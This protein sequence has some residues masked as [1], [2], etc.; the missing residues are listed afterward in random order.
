[1]ARLIL[2]CAALLLIAAPLSAQD[3]LNLPAPLYVLLND[4][5]IERY[6]I[7]VEGVTPVTET[8][9]AFI[10]DFG[11]DALEERIAYR[12]EDGMYV[13][14]VDDPANPTQIEGVSADVPPFRGAGAT[15]AWSP[16]GDALAYTT[17]YGGRVA[18]GIN[19]TWAFAEMRESPFKSIRWSPGGRFLAAETDGNIWWVYRR[20]MITMVLTSVIPSSIG[21]AWV[22][23]AEIVFA[24]AEG[25][26]RLMNLDQA[27]AQATLLDETILYRLPHLTSDDALV[28]FGRDPAD[29]NVPEGYGRLLRLER[30]ASELTTVGTTPIALDGINWSPD[31]SLLIAFQGGV[32]ALFDPATGLGF[33][34]PIENVVAW[35]WGAPGSTLS[36]PLPLQPETT[37]AAVGLAPTVPPAEPTTPPEPTAV[38][39]TT[40]PTPL[41]QVTAQALVL[42]ADGFMLAPD[43]RGIVQVWRLPA[44]GQ[45]PSAVTFSG[46]DVSEYAVSPDGRAV[47]YVVEAELWLQLQGGQPER[48]ARLN[49]FAPAA[50]AFSPAGDVLA[51]V[52]EGSGVWLVDLEDRAPQLVLAN[53]AGGGRFYR[54]PQFSPDGAR[55]LLDVY[56]DGAVVTGI[57]TIE[58]RDLLNAPPVDPTDDRAARARWL[59]DGR[60][61]TYADANQ[62]ALD[63]G[64][65]ITYMSSAAP[66]QWIPLPADVTIRALEEIAPALVRVV[67]ADGRDAYAPLR[68]V[69]ISLDGGGE[70]PVS[71]L[72]AVIAPRLS[73]DGRFVGGLESLTEIDGVAQGAVLVVDLQTG[74][75][76]LISNPPAASG[77]KWSR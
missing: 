61:L 25:G 3:G 55:L 30:G 7:G 1:M 62:P 73:G 14:V 53:D 74:T 41:P 70:S 22:S 69:D 19:E 11:V 4:G 57:F 28:F 63:P 23:D 77:F 17:T 13:M 27:N 32:V 59:R 12:T 56:A 29:E 60:V 35:A 66:T 5:H 18:F 24:P 38:P 15:V 37:E 26:L 48:I 31:G 36:E 54:R 43:S 21:I 34:L 75:R 40:A 16:N 20:D 33:P 42:S 49:S 46:A 50:P 65:Y 44:N 47:A 67:L 2:I 76:Y 58:S 68:A 6:G 64:F 52:D 10:I 8:G 39:P 9:S 71:A 45:P 72:G 51:Y